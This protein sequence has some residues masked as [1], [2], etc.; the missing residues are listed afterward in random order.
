MANRGID[1]SELLFDNRYLVK[2]IIPLLIETLLNVTIG[3]MD[4]IMVS[5]DGEA[6]V[7]GVSLVDSLANLFVFVFS[8]FATGGAVV[9]S[10]YLGRKDRDNASSSAKQLIYLSTGFAL[11][12]MV[13]LLVFRESVVRFVF[14][15]IEE[16]VHVSSIRYL[17]PIAIS[18]PFLAITNSCNAICRSM[19]KSSITMTV[20]LVMNLVNVTGNAI[21]IYI[22]G[23]SSLGAGLASLLSRVI[24]SIIMLKVITGRNQMIRVEHIAKVRIRPDMIKRIMRIALP[25]GIE[26]GIFHIGKILVAS[27]IASFG[28]ASIAANAVFN[29]LGTFANIPGTAIGMASVTV[30]GQCCGAGNTAQARYYA[31]KLLGLT[32]LLMGMTC[33]GMYV[34]TPLL[35]GFYNLS[36]AAN[37][38]AV[39]YTRLDLIQTMLFWPLAFTVPNFLRAAG[40]VK[41]TM[42]VSISSMWLFRVICAKVLGVFLGLGLLGV[43]WAMFIDWYARGACFMLRWWKGKWEEKKV[44]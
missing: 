25:S 8:A 9:C 30:I 4:T 44:I 6:V 16:D 41:Y 7:S 13:F 26:N 20:A 11:I 40:D 19:G 43:F 34:L 2:L 33:L 38:M 27:T 31:K 28:T 3:M 21:T 42:I 10:Q 15:S 29:S 17:L 37:V 22:F 18:F 35:A 32:Y 1:K 36:E 14:G 12:I 23:L 24:A 5:T 39:D